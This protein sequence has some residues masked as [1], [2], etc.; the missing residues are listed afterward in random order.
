VALC[1]DLTLRRE[2]RGSLD[3]V[4]RHLWALGAERGSH[5]V[6]TTGARGSRA[7]LRDPGNIGITEADIAQALKAV[8][9]RSYAAELKAW[10][11]GKGELPVADL[12][13]TVGLA[14]SREAERLSAACGLRL[15]EGPV[16]GCV[17]CRVLRGSA[18]EAAGLCAGDEIL[19]VQ[20]WRVRRLDDAA[21]WLAAQQHQERANKG[22]NQ[23]SRPRA[24]A[25]AA[26]ALLV[27]RDQRILTLTLQPDPQA[28]RVPT[29][30]WTVDGAGTK[31]GP[32]SAAHA[33]DAKGVAVSE[34]RRAWWSA[35]A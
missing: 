9:G 6:A 17:V 5:V 14:Q 10:V 3:A 34:R 20:G 28:T 8:G 15:S 7:A 18:A 11:H 1:L 27:N 25:P 26:V 32:G 24:A 4:M 16:T 19:A 29:L 13:P 30:Q 31:P 12:L 2:G 21:Q 35:S 33:A 23:A 22:S